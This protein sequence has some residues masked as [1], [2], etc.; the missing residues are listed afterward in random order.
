MPRRSV[1]VESS[2]STS[3][4]NESAAAAAVGP[5]AGLV[6]S[7]SVTAS[8]VGSVAGASGS[9]AGSGE[10]SGAGR[11]PGHCGNGTVLVVFGDSALDIVV[12]RRTA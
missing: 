4:V 11:V 8:G 1:R 6:R 2:S 5:V 12:F 3:K 7:V 10:G 9:G